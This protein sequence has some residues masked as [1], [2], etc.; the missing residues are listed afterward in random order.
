MP[1]T[2]T[3]RPWP[4]PVI[5]TLGHDPR[6]VYVES[7][8]LPTLG[9]TSILLLRHLA[10][11]F[12]SSPEG[13][14]LPLADTSQALGLGHREGVSSPLV[15]TLARL[16]QFDI[17]R[18]DGHGAVDV[19]RNLPPVNRR[20]LRRLPE[21]LQVAHAEWAEARIGEAPLVEARRRARRIALALVDE[22]GDIDGVERA[23]HGIGY[24]PSI[25]RES[26]TW[27]WGHHHIEDEDIHGSEVPTA[28]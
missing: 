6:S 1:T 28:S 13:V 22:G 21:H 27:A 20:H 16:A 11:R 4:D 3:V 17:A 25:C 19:R 10:A 18:E 24:H 15:R 14:Q 23:L 5:D 12:E 8:W 26:A 7:F 9:P 2:I